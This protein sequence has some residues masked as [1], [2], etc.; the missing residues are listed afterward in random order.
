MSAGTGSKAR[1]TSKEV[2]Q[3]M[4]DGRLP[5]AASSSHCTKDSDVV[6][7]GIC[8]Q[9]Q[10]RKV[11]HPKGPVVPENPIR[12]GFARGGESAHHLARWSHSFSCVERLA[13]NCSGRGA[14]LKARTP[15]F[16]ISLHR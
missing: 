13:P 16:A 4:L 11:R 8:L 2:A 7:R 9:E 15:V 1:M 3:W 6:W 5:L 14:S 10:E 12:L